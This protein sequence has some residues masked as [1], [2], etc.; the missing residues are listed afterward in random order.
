MIG[1]VVVGCHLI[2][3][4]FPAAKTPSI[5]AS[6]FSLFSN[7]AALARAL[8]AQRRKVVRRIVNGYRFSKRVSL[9]GTGAVEVVVCIRLV[10]K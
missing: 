1:P 5:G 4:G 3:V 2:V 8:S 7:E 10:V 6:G 9:I